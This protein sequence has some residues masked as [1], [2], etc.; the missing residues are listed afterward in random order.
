[1]FTGG[2]V[3]GPAGQEMTIAE[4]A[5]FALYEAKIQP[6][7]TASH[8]SNDSPPP[9]AAQGLAGDDQDDT[10]G[11]GRDDAGGALGV[12]QRQDAVQRATVLEGAGLLQVLEF[13]VEL[14]T[15]QLA[16]FLAVGTGCQ[17]DVAGDPLAC[18]FDLVDADHARM[19][20]CFY[21][22]SMIVTIQIIKSD[23]EEPVGNQ[24][25]ICR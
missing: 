25:P 22:M 15:G 19:T 1:M 18:K 16:E 21:T 4:A 13:Q 8:M 10:G 23:R 7:A 5:L 6:M 3:S 24:F 12:R 9:F 14:A 20:S 2:I 17:Q 11:R